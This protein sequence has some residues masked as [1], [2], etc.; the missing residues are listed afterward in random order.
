VA[1]EIRFSRGDFIVENEWGYMTGTPWIVIPAN[2]F[3]EKF[4][5]DGK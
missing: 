4:E 2:E 1:T 5:E 3:C